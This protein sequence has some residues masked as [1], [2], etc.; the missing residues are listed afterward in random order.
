MKINRLLENPES[1]KYDLE[2]ARRIR[3][4]VLYLQA[5]LAEI[6][7][8]CVFEHPK[9]M[10]QE[11]GEVFGWTVLATNDEDKNTL[12]FTV[13]WDRASVMFGFKLHG[14]HINLAKD[15]SILGADIDKA[16]KAALD[17]I[18]EHFHDRFKTHITAN[19]VNTEIEKLGSEDT[20][21]AHLVKSYL[22]PMLKRFT[23]DI[24]SDNLV[25]SEKL[26]AKL[27]IRI[28]DEFDDVFNKA[29]IE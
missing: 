8:S 2:H 29:V 21:H 6:G 3:K 25:N 16:Y 26:L 27:K 12:K 19:R 9:P 17:S 13:H 11:T 10:D 1:T 7:W 4:T 24:K 22:T 23:D 28:T 15:Y 18:I 20:A 5:A 14:F